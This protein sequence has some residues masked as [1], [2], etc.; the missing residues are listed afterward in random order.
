MRSK[1]DFAYV[2]IC[3]GYGGFYQHAED[4]YPYW[5]TKS[6]IANTLARGIRQQMPFYTCCNLSMK[7]WIVA[8]LL[9]DCSLLISQRDLILLTTPLM[10][11][12]AKLEVHPVLLKWIA[13]GL[14]DQSVASS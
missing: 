3:E 10:Q 7:R 5:M 12:L 1:T 4:L 9:L 13:P 11:E 14:P 8:R 2:H 6:T